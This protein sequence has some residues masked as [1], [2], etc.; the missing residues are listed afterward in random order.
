MC[1]SEKQQFKTRK[2]EKKVHEIEQEEDDVMFLGCL[3]IRP[4]EQPDSKL[5]LDT[6]STV[7]NSSKK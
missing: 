7:K 2:T 3:E 1:R 6:V 5:Q 4:N